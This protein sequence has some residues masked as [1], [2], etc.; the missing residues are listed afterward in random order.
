MLD[1][2]LC[3]VRQ[4]DIVEMEIHLLNKHDVDVCPDFMKYG[5]PEARAFFD[6]D[7]WADR[8]LELYAILLLKGER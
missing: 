4:C 1:C 6:A 3:S 2:P 8:V 7:D 5:S